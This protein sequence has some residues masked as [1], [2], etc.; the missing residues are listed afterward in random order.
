M[1]SAVGGG[2]GS[3]KSKQKEQ[4]QLIYDSD[5]GGGGKKIRKFCGRHISIAPWQ[6]SRNPAPSV[7]ASLSVIL[8]VS[9]PPR[10]CFAVAVIHAFEARPILYSDFAGIGQHN[11]HIHIETSMLDVTYIM[12]DDQV[13]QL[14]YIHLRICLDL[15]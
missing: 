8:N 14:K 13:V 4:N 11:Q 2:R 3:P 9:R 15:V 10:R 5:K 12:Y 1:M 7:P 6:S